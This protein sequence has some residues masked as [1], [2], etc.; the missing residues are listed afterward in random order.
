VARQP[1]FVILVRGS[2]CGRCATTGRTTP[3]GGPPLH[4]PW[5]VILCLTRH[6]AWRSGCWTR[7]SGQT[8]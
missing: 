7:L 4:H 2:N 1:L 3:A 5:C 6:S 8:T